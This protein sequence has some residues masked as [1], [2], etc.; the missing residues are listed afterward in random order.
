MSKNKAF[1]I[2]AKVTFKSFED[3]KVGVYLDAFPIIG[4]EAKLFIIL[5]G[6]DNRFGESYFEY[7]AM[8]TAV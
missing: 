6:F 8:L 2:E 7:Q 3:L 1:D 5:K 4:V